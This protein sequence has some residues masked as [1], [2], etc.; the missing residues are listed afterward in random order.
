MAISFPS[1]PTTGD[2]YTYNNKTWQWNGEGWITFPTQNDGAIA[3][4]AADVDIQRA[5]AVREANVLINPQFA[6]CIEYSS[7]S[8]GT[9]GSSGVGEHL[10]ENWYASWSV[11]TGSIQCSTAGVGAADAPCGPLYWRFNAN[12]GATLA[13]ASYILLEHRIEGMFLRP[14]QWD[15]STARPLRI[16]FYIRSSITGTASCSLSTPSFGD[17]YLENITINAANTWEWKE[18]EVPPAIPANIPNTTVQT[19]NL[20]G[21]YLRICIGN[22]STYQGTS[23]TWQAGNKTGTSSTTNFMATTNNTVDITNLVLMDASNEFPVDV[24]AYNQYMFRDYDEETPK[25]WRYYQI[26]YPLGTSTGAAQSNGLVQWYTGQTS[27]YHCH[28]VQT[29]VMMRAVPTVTVYSPVT[30]TASKIRDDSGAVDVNG[31]AVY[32]T[33]YSFQGRVNNVSVAGSKFLSFQWEADAR[34]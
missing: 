4:A 11:S 20:I 9:A 31:S 33:R 22:G 10:A 14:F 3:Y 19:W 32:S 17:T 13:A 21:A 5:L 24:A 16:G 12:T 23:G 30:G 1:S 8:S 6:V 25:V 27:S 18:I 34:L 7:G 26:S 28:H 15:E 29:R 2:L